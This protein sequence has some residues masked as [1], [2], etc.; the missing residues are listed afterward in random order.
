MS[1][2]TA[3]G[4]EM[5]RSRIARAVPVNTGMMEAVNE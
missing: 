2:A 3:S 4:Q 5:D 1:M